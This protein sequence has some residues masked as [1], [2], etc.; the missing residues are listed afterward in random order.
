MKNK[1]EV[2]VIIGGGRNMELGRIYGELR[3]NYFG[4]IFIFKLS[5]VFVVFYFIV[6]KINTY[7]LILFVMYLILYKKDIFFFYREFII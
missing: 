1:I 6:I 3:I 4:N 2:V 7:L 5:G